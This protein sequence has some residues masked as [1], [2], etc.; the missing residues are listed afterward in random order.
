M[1][2]DERERAGQD[3]VSCLQTREIDSAREAGAIEN[4]FV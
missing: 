2:S 3:I 1:L 4:D